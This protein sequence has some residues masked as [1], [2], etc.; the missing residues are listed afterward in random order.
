M[1]IKFQLVDD[2]DEHLM[3]MY[4]SVYIPDIGE[5]VL[6]NDAKNDVCIDELAK[7]VG[8]FYRIDK[9]ILTIEC[10]IYNQPNDYGY[11]QFKKYNG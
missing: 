10:K 11:L 6:F 2:Y 8:K 3:Y 9:N 4:G 7:V 5:D 1:K